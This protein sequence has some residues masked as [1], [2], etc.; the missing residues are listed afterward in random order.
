MEKQPICDPC[1]IHVTGDWVLNEDGEYIPF[2]YSIPSHTPGHPLERCCMCNSHTI[3][4][5]YIVR[6]ASAVPFPTIV[7][8]EEGDWL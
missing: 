2:S 4:G 6:K 8:E 1:W 5:I 7:P 3:A